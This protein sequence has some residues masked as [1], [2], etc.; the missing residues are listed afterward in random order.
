MSDEE[1]ILIREFL[2]DLKNLPSLTMN[3][4]RTTITIRDFYN[5]VI[6]WEERQLEVKP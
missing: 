5:L 4:T 6:K 2:D 1:I 3:G